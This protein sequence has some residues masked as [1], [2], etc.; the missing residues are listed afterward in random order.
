MRA[1]RWSAS[2]WVSPP[3]W[4]I[5]KPSPSG[6]SSQRVRVDALDPLVVDEAVVQCPP[7]AIGSCGRI[8]GTASAAFDDR[9][10]AEYDE[11]AFLH[12]GDELELGAQHRDKRRLAADQQ[13]GDVEA[14]LSG[15]SESR[16]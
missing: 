2:S 14:V 12:D 15:S 4:T 16:L 5:R 6:R 13:P 3:N 8:A 1:R 9:V 7:A 10:E 11:G